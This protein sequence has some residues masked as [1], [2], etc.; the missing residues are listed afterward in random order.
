ML[1]CHLPKIDGR[2]RR[3][4]LAHLFYLLANPYVPPPPNAECFLP[5]L[6]K[7]ASNL[8]YPMEIRNQTFPSYTPIM[9]EDLFGTNA[10]LSLVTLRCVIV[11][12][13]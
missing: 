6:C 9:A 12:V 10:A 8:L 13:C 3:H 1:G 2:N 4:Q 5:H 7:I 11:V